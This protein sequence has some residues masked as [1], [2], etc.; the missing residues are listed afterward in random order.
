MKSHSNA[1]LSSGEGEETH[2]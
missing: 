2:M 1:V